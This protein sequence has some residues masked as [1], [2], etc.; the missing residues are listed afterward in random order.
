M[1]SIMARCGEDGIHFFLDGL[2]LSAFGLGVA[3]ELILRR[4]I[5]ATVSVAGLRWDRDR[6]RLYLAITPDVP[7]AGRN[8]RSPD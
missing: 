7:R 2:D 6:F 5:G 1:T 8:T 3:Y 4:K